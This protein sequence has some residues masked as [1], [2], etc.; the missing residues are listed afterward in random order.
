V[1]GGRGRWRVAALLGA[2]RPAR[3]Q[4][5]QPGCCAL[6]GLLVGRPSAVALG[7]SMCGVMLGVL[8][9]A[10]RC[11]A[12]LPSDAAGGEHR[13]A[14]GRCSRLPE[15]GRLLASTPAGARVGVNM[16]VNQPAIRS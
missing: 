8:L 4:L 3:E 9:Q 13:G 11:P 16:A 7:P 6:P 12:A 2:C 15:R 1:S 14:E 5:L 10:V